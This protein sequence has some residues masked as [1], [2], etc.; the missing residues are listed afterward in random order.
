[1]EGKV[2]ECR[3][4]CLRIGDAAF[5]GLTRAP[6]TCE[7]FSLGMGI[8]LTSEAEKKVR[9]AALADEHNS[10]TG[11]IQY[12]EPGTPFGFRYM[13]AV[14]KACGAKVTARK[15]RMG[16]AEGEVAAE[17]I[18]PAG[19]KVAVFDTEPKYVIILA[20]ANGVTPAF[21]ERIMGEVE[22]MFRQ[23]R[24]GE[25]LPALYTTDTH[26]VNTVRGVVN[27]LKEDAKI[28]GKI[29]ELVAAAYEDMGDAQF[30]GERALVGIKALGAKQAIGIV[31]TVNAIVAVARIA[32]PL[33]IF[34]G[35]IATLWVISKI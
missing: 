34:G 12:V 7:D 1:V 35:I 14:G 25:V 19:I 31:S 15:L 13:E 10:E 29:L 6:E 22:G 30:Y 26:K 8:A 3:A 21:R 18:G 33:I 28:M 16:S 17:T 5:V 9:L 24:W 27:P 23:K 2:G 11:E 20:D 4:E 32:A